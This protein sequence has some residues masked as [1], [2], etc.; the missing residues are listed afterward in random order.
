MNSITVQRLTIGEGGN[1][2][3]DNVPLIMA[4]ETWT[5]LPGLES[6]FC[7]LF[8]M[9]IFF[10]FFKV[11]FKILFIHERNTQRER[12]RERERER[13]AEGE[14]GSMKGGLNPGSP[15]PRPGPKTVLNC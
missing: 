13:Q 1:S 11:F 10:L 6:Q 14:A 12:L 9:Y 3:E 2:S 5:L 15:G 7:H 4:V 8:A